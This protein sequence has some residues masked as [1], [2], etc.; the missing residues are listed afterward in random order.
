MQH[1]IQQIVAAL[2][3]SLPLSNHSVHSLDEE[4]PI[5]SVLLLLGATKQLAD[6]WNRYPALLGVRE[7]PRQRCNERMVRVVERIE[8]VAE[9]APSDDFQRQS[10]HCVNDRNRCPLLRREMG[11]EF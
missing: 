5:S 10:S 7:R 3:R 1:P 9:T 4:R 2:P 11:T 8:R 6:E